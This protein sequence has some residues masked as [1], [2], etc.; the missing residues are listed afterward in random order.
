[1]D[2]LSFQSFLTEGRTMVFDQ[3]WTSVTGDAVHLW[4]GSSSGSGLLGLALRDGSTPQLR[5]T[6]WL[7]GSGGA[8]LLLQD[9]SYTEDGVAAGQDRM[10][11]SSGI[12]GGAQFYTVGP[13]GGLTGSGA[14]TDAANRPLSVSEFTCFEQQGQSYMAA[15]SGA[16]EGLSLYRLSEGMSR[17][18]LLD[19]VT[20]TPKSTATG[21][22]DVLSFEQGGTRFVLS[23][24]GT[25]DGLSVYAVTGGQLE[26]RDTLGPKDGLWI[27]GLEDVALLSAGGQTFAI[28]LSAL[29]GT[30]S[31]V[32]INPM[33][34]L[35]VED[36]LHDSLDTRFGGARAMDTFEAAGRSFIVAGGNDGG[37]ALI[38]LLP[39]GALYHHQSI[40]QDAGWDIGAIQGLQAEVLGNE[41]QLFVSGA[42]APGIVRLSMPLADIGPLQQGGGGNDALSGGASDDL[43]MGR[44]GNDTLIGGAGDDTL[45]AGPGADRLTGGAGADVF[46]LTADGQVDRITDFQPGTDRIDLDDWGM[47]YDISALR[48]TATNWGGRIFWQDQQVDIYLE[49][50]GSLDPALWSQ[51]DFL[52]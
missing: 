21:I 52:F 14:L 49:G 28:G 30:L 35:F 17:A 1:M 39:G 20:D 36:I 43:L 9:M 32:R 37:L 15:A 51:D 31:A 22:S 10:L 46:V 40:V 24:S 3:L 44:W 11:I 19:S 42:A 5:S 7:T 16:R 13:G 12:A 18:T 25:E 41:L 33:G 2:R 47:V 45:F 23:A 27:D 38:E 48:F 8:T 29:S 6:T 34:V 26:L 4:A 50:G